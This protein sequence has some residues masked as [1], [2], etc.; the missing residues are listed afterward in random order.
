MPRIAPVSPPYEPDVAAQLERMMPPGV[1]PIALFRT[2]ARNLPTAE[3]MGRWGAHQLGRGL[4]L[5]Q[6]V[7]ELPAA[8]EGGRRRHRRITR[9]RP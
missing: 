5:V 6:R 3:A 8:V 7:G 1:P 2:F 9:G 4:T